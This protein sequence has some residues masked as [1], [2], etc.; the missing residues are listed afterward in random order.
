M[1]YIP[2]SPNERDAM[3]A[4]IDVRRL[5]D[6]FKDVPVKHRFPKL[7]LPPALTEMEAAA[8]LDELANGNENLRG[9]LVSFLGAGAYNHYI[10][11]VV[12][13]ILRR[14]EFYTAYTPYQPEISQGTLQAIFEYQSLMCALTG[15][16]VSNASHYDGATAVAEAVSMAYAQFRGKRTKVVLSPSVHPQYRATL[17]TYA[18]GMGLDLA[19][20]NA[21]ADLGSG[22]EAL[23][24]LLDE[25]TA[26]VI[27]QYPDFFGRIYDYTSL[28]EAAHAQG[29]L[30]CVAANPIALAL[31]KTPGEMGADIVVGEG[32]PLGIPLSYGG[33]YLGFFTTRKQYI[34]KMA[35]RLVGETVDN[36][37]QRAYVLTLTARE[38][39]IKRERATSNICSNQGLMALAAAV[40]LSL[41][42]KRGLRQ[43]AELCYHKAHYAAMQIAKIPGYSLCF[44]AP[45]FH[46]FSVCCPK[47]VAEINDHLLEHGILGGYDLGQDYP[48]LKNHL[49]IAVTEMNSKEEIDALVE[50]LSEV[51]HD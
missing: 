47:P 43:V 13:H 25:N 16:E 15:M 18:Q 20:D 17:R 26:L 41:A 21:A 39:H 22:P 40:Y 45:F 44:E 14:G 5:E 3:L 27:V 7:D 30:V 28:I 19:G 36:R 38:Q 42:G 31:L 33:P 4:I 10:P 37:G 51:K 34:H 24:S 23:E 2:I 48:A 1:T 9:D 11:S 6:L 32:Q 46:E 49:L 50:V 35:G 12:D 29:A 8:E